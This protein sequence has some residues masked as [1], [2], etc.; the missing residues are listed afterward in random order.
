[1]VDGRT[2][3][4]RSNLVA[5]ASYPGIVAL[6][7][8]AYGVFLALG[9]A[10]T[11]ASSTAV[12]IGAGL[13]TL[14]E[15]RIPYRREWH[16]SASDVRS[17][18]L[19]LALVQFAL[20]RVLALTLVIALADLLEGAGLTVDGFWP[21]GWVVAAQVCLMLALADL[22]RYWLHR[23][24]HRF[25]PMWRLHSVHHSPHRLYWLNVG[26]FHPIEKLI[27][28]TV[29]TLPFALLG[30]SQEV[31]AAYFVFYAINGFFQHSNCD[32]RL[33]FLNYIVSGPELHRWHHSEL[34]EESNHN[35][36]NNLIIWDALFGTRFLPERREVGEL[37]LLNRL[38]PLGFLAQM[39]TPFVRGLNP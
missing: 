6:G 39:R 38:Y 30:V 5:V 4:A 28:Y 37:G 29:D 20:P 2:G 9:W 8:I 12:V 25:A 19:F 21:H 34:P 23:A 33:G 3:T 26:R 13:V 14:H 24:F 7:F 16:P 22:P 36:G 35:F 27:Q 10:P 31:L 32:V 11:L 17:D 15:V 18:G 1:M